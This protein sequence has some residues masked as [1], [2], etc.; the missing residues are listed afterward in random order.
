MQ[1]AWILRGTFL[2]TEAD[3]RYREGTTH[4]RSLILIPSDENHVP[5]EEQMTRLR[6]LRRILTLVVMLSLLTSILAACG[7]TESATPGTGSAGATAT[8]GTGATGGE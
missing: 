6:G 1:M 3:G 2:D 8:T 4:P 7:G 5:K